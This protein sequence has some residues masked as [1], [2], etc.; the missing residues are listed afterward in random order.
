MGDAAPE[1]T[2]GNSSIVSRFT[3]GSNPLQP[4]PNAANPYSLRTTRPSWS[5]PK[6]AG[7]ENSTGQAVAESE[8]WRKN[9]PRIVLFIAGG[10]TFSEIRGAYEV[11]KNYKRDILIGKQ[12]NCYHNFKINILI[13]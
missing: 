13:I 10:A 3:K 12:L 4:L 6:P 8:D 5:K 9:G 11:M 2:K 1:D 7:G